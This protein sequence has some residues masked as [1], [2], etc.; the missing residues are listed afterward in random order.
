VS[1]VTSVWFYI[2][3]GK[4][5]LIFRLSFFFFVWGVERE[6]WDVKVGNNSQKWILFGGWRIMVL[7]MNGFIVLH[8]RLWGFCLGVSHHPVGII[9]R[10]KSM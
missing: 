1:F 5:N 3:K 4:Y 8:L 9:C 6:A 2:F 10:T 7:D